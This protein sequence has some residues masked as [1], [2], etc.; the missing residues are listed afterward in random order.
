M[1]KNKS[2]IEVIF[3]LEKLSDMALLGALIARHN[4]DQRHSNIKEAVIEISEK[5]SA[6]LSITDEGLQELQNIID[7]AVFRY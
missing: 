7:E 1:A 3:N 6:Y 4:L 2:T 5:E